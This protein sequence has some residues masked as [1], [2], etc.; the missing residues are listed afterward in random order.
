M[1]NNQNGYTLLE[2]MIALVLGLLIVAAGTM[3]FMF[4]L[5]STTLQSSMSEL[6]QNANF[7]LGMLMQDLRH[8]NLNTPSVQKINN[9]QV[10]A[11]IVFSASNLP[12]SLSSVSANLFTRQNNDVSALTI[13]SDQLTIQYIPQ[14]VTVTTKKCKSTAL[15][16]PITNTCDTSVSSNLE[17]ITTYEARSTDCEGNELKFSEPRVVVQRYHVKADSNQI[18]GQPTAYSLYCDAGTYMAGEAFITGMSAANNG[19]Q[20]MQRIDA[21]KVSLGVQDKDKKLRYM[22]INTYISLMGPTVLNENNYYNILSLEAGLIAR[23]TSAMPL[24]SMIN[25]NKKFKM[26]NEEFELSTAQR[27]GPKYL[28]EAFSQVVAFRNTLGAS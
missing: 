2:L 12:S 28:R 22:S 21:F 20:L 17:D 6:Q 9:K 13:N 8:A 15:I 11:G 16:N 4:G 14:Y 25:N 5:R 7:G 3:I 27:N 19:Q 23:S 26:L 18:L 24:E 1:T 10:G